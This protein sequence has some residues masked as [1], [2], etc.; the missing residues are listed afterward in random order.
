LIF[1]LGCSAVVDGGAVVV[2]GGGGLSGVAVGVLLR[3]EVTGRV[4]AGLAGGDI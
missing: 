3:G 1:F 2:D 4:I